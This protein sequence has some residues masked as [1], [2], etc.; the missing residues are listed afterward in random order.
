MTQKQ[1]H[2]GIGFLSGFA[3]YGVGFLLI[4]WIISLFTSGPISSSDMD[5]LRDYWKRYKVY[6]DVKSVY[7]AQDGTIKLD[8]IQ[9]FVFEANDV[10]QILYQGNRKMKADQVV[11]YLGG[12]DTTIGTTTYPSLRLIALG[13]EKGYLL[14]NKYIFDHADPIPPGFAGQ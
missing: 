10:R 6:Q 5:D 4:S 2:I 12:K 13:A 8:Q 11:F 1:K 7:K 14:K 3:T 9:G